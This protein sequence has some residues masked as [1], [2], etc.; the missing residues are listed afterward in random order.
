MDHARRRLIGWVSL[1]A[2]LSGAVGLGVPWV[3]FLVDPRAGVAQ[4]LMGEV[5]SAGLSPI[6]TD[7]WG[8]PLHGGRVNGGRLDYQEGDYWSA[9]PN[10]VDEEGGGDDVP[11]LAQDDPRLLPGLLARLLCPL[12]SLGVGA[13]SLLVLQRRALADQA[14]LLLPALGAASAAAIGVPL[15]RAF[16]RFAPEALPP[17]SRPV[18]VA[19]AIVGGLIAGWALIPHRDP[20]DGPPP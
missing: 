3:W 17:Y 10:G 13:G 8:N 18:L 20:D 11:V 15:I 4:S 12:V 16:K 14:R 9:G 1:A 6:G 5:G 7:P 2:A 19:T